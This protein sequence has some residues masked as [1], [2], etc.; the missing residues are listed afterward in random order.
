MCAAT[1]SDGPQGW[2]V[3]DRLD[4][5]FLLLPDLL[6]SQC[7]HLAACAWAWT[8]VGVDRFNWVE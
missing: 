5:L 8:A 2:K 6:V 4:L 7:P 1:P 3:T